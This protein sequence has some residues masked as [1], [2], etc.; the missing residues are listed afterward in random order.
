MYIQLW[1]CWRTEL[2]EI[3]LCK[4]KKEEKKAIA[5]HIRPSQIAKNYIV[6]A[7][8]QI[9]KPECSNRSKCGWNYWSGDKLGGVWHLQVAPIKCKKYK[10][11]AQQQIHGDSSH[12]GQQQ[13]TR[14]ALVVIVLKMDID[15]TIFYWT[16]RSDCFTTS[17]QGTCMVVNGLMEKTSSNRVIIS[18]CGAVIVQ[19]RHR[20][21]ALS[22]Q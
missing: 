1:Q 6:I 11:H 16:I 9:W 21:F 18:V 17:A 19:A 22:V 14:H 15:S 10:N 8:F 5:S 4:K 13:T 12:V 2:R 20:A 7:G 3:V